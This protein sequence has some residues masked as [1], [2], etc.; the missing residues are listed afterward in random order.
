MF[1]NSGDSQNDLNGFLDRG[2]RLSGELHFDSSFRIDGRFEGKISSSGRLIVGESG[3][4][5]GDI[6]VRHVAVSGQLRGTVK[7]DEQIHIA[8][9]GR[10]AADLETPSL[11]IEDGAQFDGRCSMARQSAKADDALPKLVSRT[12]AP[13]V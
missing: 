8:A 2:S 11:L 9:G 13:E 3:E 4:V 10:V 7:A 12:V 5:E 1:K 6:H